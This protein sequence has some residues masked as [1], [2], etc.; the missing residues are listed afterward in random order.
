M[1]RV[2]VVEDEPVAAA[3]HRSYVDRVPGFEVVAIAHTAGE[4][5]AALAHARVDLILLDMRLPDAHGLDLLRRARARGFTC[6]VIAVTSVRDLEIVRRAMA[7]GVTHYILKP[8][9]FA[10]LRAKLVQFAQW[11]AHLA[12]VTGGI[13]QTDVDRLFELRRAATAPSGPPK[14]LSDETLAEVTARL[15]E[16]ATPQ[17]ASEVGD[18]VGTSR[19]TARRYLEH[20]VEQGVATRQTRHGQTGRPEVLYR[21]V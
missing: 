17:S 7:Q 8:F 16:A 4:A 1:I 3:A 12:G 10:S 15:R 11:R 14:G 13:A 18:A 19:V 6:D 20:L 2:L 21:W 5:A 9:T